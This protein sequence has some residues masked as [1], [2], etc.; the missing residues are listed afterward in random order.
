MLLLRRTL[1]TEELKLDFLLLFA[2]TGRLMPDVHRTYEIRCPIHGFVTLN[3][4]EW[5]IISQPA[6]QR[7]RRI[8]QL[9]WTDYIYPGAMHT[10]FEHSL[11]VMHT[12]TLLYDSIIKSSK[13]ILTSELAY[14]DTG[15]LRSRQLVRLAALVH[16]V[17]H[18]PFSHASEDL[19]PDRD[20]RKRFV[21]E[22]Y[23]VAIIRSDLRQAIEEHPLNESY[24][25]EADDIAALIEGSTKAK[26]SVFWRPLIDGQ[27]DADRMDYLLRDSYHAGVQY[28]K[29]DLHRLVS[30]IRP[31]RYGDGRAPRLG[32][33]EGGWHAA[34]ALVLARYFMFTQVYFHKTRVAYDV[35]LRGALKEI[36]PGGRYPRPLNG[37][38]KEFLKWDDWAVLGILSQGGGGE[39]GECLRTRNHFRLIYHTNEVPDEKNLQQLEKVKAQLGSLVVAEEPASKSWYKTGPTDIPVV[40]GLDETIV[41]PLSYYSSVVKNLETNSQVLLYARREDSAKAK[42][43]VNE[44]R[45]HDR[46]VA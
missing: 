32:I 14:D 5:E 29:F 38:L 42:K 24:G 7:L 27:M 39:H 31:V 22:D 23:S 15:F 4:W 40:D 11:G 20:G 25:F 6:F 18:A 33:A 9:G 3:D 16:D 8:R 43:L 34:E 30:T 41:K 37:E 45:D 12:A 10:R 13:S 1:F 2:Y 46:S 21:H 17:G 36:L 44:V 28:G 19:F 26:Q 35:H